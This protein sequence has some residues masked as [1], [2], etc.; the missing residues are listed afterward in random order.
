M[1]DWLEK[2]AQ[3][4]PDRVALVE[5]RTGAATTFGEWNVRAN[6]TA[7][8]LVRLGVG[9]GDLVSVIA[10]NR[11]EYLDLLF[12]CNKTGSVLHNLNWRLAVPELSGILA[13]AQPR[14]LAYS[15]E[16]REVVE[17]LRPELP[18]VRH[19]IAIEGD[20]GDDR[21]LD[22]RDTC[23][24]TLQQIVR[25]EADDAWAIYYTGGTTGLPKGAVLTHGNMTWNS[26]NTVVSWG[27]TADDVAPLQL[28]FFHIGGPNIFMLPL[29]HV[30]GRSI[31]CTGFDADETF[32]LI[33]GGVITHYV[34][35]PTMYLMMQQH[36]RWAATD[37]SR[38][39]LVI[40]GGA[41]CPLPVM[42]RF[43]DRGVDFKVGYGL[44]EAA[45]N[46]F[47]LPPEL[48][49]SRPGA[50]G[51]PLFHIDMR[52]VR[53]DGSDCAPDEV[54]ELLIRGP[55]VFA[56]YWCQPGAT[57]DAIRDGWLHTGDLAHRAADGCYSI[58]GRS[59]EMFI[60]GGEN[61]Y[62]AEVESVLHAHP[63][64]AEAAL[65][66]VPHETWGEVGRAIVVVQ[67]G[68]QLDE[69]ELIAF[70][71]Q[72]LARYKLPRSVVFVPALPRTAIGKIDRNQLTR[73]Y[74]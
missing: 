20:A 25:V 66:A 6:R 5:T 30:G 8:L 63:A 54:G 42:Q 73:Q 36:A 14:V 69:A 46:N 74:A 21:A 26:V 45:G 43:W 55:H 9:K 19:F 52:V 13:E 31:L 23:A 60:S 72:R 22:E 10:G 48:V 41:P 40:S 56:G 62:P 53:D 32:D 64:V 17:R 29:V 70:I 58:V 18:S 39:R 28:P 59:K 15:A 44:T 7:N 68:R 67:H 47:W 34:G 38:L 61:V 16:W 33:D 71:E 50:V 27:V 35:V 49:R 11:A 1:P 65:I 4:T 3:L 57:A 51:Y 37:F 12:A 24:D 2:R